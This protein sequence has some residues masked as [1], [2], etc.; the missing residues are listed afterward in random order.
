MGCYVRVCLPPSADANAWTS[1]GEDVK[2]TGFAADVLTSCGVP[3]R[4]Y[5]DGCFGD[6]RS[7]ALLV[8]TLDALR[9]VEKAHMALLDA[10][11]GDDTTY[12]V[13]SY[14][15]R[16]IVLYHTVVELRSRGMAAALF[17]C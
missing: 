1:I 10:D 11:A 8:A 7:S 16:W 12:D 14:V 3:A 6:S 4:N 15:Q 9:Q 13:M 5:D 17:G 2:Y